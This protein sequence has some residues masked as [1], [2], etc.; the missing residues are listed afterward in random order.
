VDHVDGV[1][2][3]INAI[4]QKDQKIVSF[5]EKD[6]IFANQFAFFAGVA[7]ERALMLR[8]VV[9]KMVELA[10]LRDPKETQAHVKRVGSYALEIYQKWAEIHDVPKKEINNYGD[11]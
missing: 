9:L 5:R 10:K 4:N 8:D 2:Q 11:I 3:L 7:I 6:L 1:L